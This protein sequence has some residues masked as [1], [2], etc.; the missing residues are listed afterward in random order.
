MNGELVCRLGVDVGGT[1]TG[2]VLVTQDGRLVTRK[3]LSTS[4]NYAEAT[5]F[6]SLDWRR[7]GHRHFIWR[8]HCGL[9]S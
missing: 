9:K 2:L 8:T 4:S 3:V 5:A 7:D 6:G 1:F